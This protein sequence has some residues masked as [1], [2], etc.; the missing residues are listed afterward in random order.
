M[1]RPFAELL[2]AGMTGL[3]L[4][5][6]VVADTGGVV[7]SAL[8]RAGLT[9]AGAPALLAVAVGRLDEECWS[10]LE[11]A[12]LPSGRIEAISFPPD[13]PHEH[14]ASLVAGAAGLEPPPV[15]VP[16][17]PGAG[18]E[19]TSNVLRFD[20]TAH[21]LRALLGSRL[22]ASDERWPA[23]VRCMTDA[24][25]TAIRADGTVVLPT[26]GELVRLRR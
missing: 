2:A 13:S 26:W 18:I 21:A 24:L 25:G 20:G 22:E 1:V 9:V 19:R 15:A 12:C 23:A 17:P 4:R 8:T 5:A 3:P 6:H 16:A 14:L 7:R 10:R 11:A